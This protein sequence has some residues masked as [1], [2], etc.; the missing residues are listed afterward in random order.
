[1]KTGH[2]QPVEEARILASLC[3]SSKLDYLINLF[4]LIYFILIYFN[5]F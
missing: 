1:M 2:G 4:N 3:V 5:L